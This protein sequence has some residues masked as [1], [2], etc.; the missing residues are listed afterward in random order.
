M[1]NEALKEEL[2]EMGIEKNKF[3]TSDQIHSLDN[4]TYKK[5]FG[6]DAA[7]HMFFNDAIYINRDYILRN[8]KLPKIT[9]LKIMLHEIA[10]SYSFKKYHVNIDEDINHTHYTGYRYGYQVE[11]PDELN[12]VH[13]K[14]FNEAVT[15][16]ITLEIKQKHFLDI[17]KK[18][19]FPQE[20]LSNI[21]V[22]TDL[23]STYATQKEILKT[24]IKK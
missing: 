5:M 13:F 19:N 24:I 15:E 21:D 18:L 7:V 20:E 14:G 12:H 16:E 1:A 9:Y 8:Y 22:E 11:N 2:K 17:L 4:E 23:N 3:V 10:H 6:N